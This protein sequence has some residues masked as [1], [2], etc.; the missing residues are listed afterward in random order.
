MGLYAYTPKGL[1]PALVIR[2]VLECTGM[3]GGDCGG[4]RRERPE[5]RRFF[6]HVDGQ[7]RME[8]LVYVLDDAG[9]DGLSRTQIAPRIAFQKGWT[10]YLKDENPGAFRRTLGRYLEQ[11]RSEGFVEKVGQN[12]STKYVLRR[13]PHV[14]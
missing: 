13:Y 6:N 9:D 7:W 1:F 11:L 4:A 5:V 10:K 14:E 2:D 8:E 3:E 12:Q